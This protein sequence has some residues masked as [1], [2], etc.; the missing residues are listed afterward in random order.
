MGE[1]VIIRSKLSPDLSLAELTVP[2]ELTEYNFDEE[3]VDRE[4]MELRMKNA[5][6]VEAAS[7][8]GGD[9]IELMVEERGKCF[10]AT[11]G[12]GLLGKATEQS[13]L[14]MKLGE[15][16]IPT[17]GPFNGKCVT[18]RDIKRRMI[19]DF[20]D[21]MAAGLGYASAS[22]YRESRMET[23]RSQARRDKARELT[24]TE[25]LSRIEQTELLPFGTELE[26]LIRDYRGI[27]EE[28]FRSRSMDEAS[29]KAE[30]LEQMFGVR[31][32]EELDKMT[33][34]SAET[35]L[36]MA[37]VGQKIAME[38]GFVFGEAE[39]EK[40]IQAH[41]EKYLMD[42]EAVRRNTSF[43]SALVEEYVKLLISEQIAR[44]ESSMKEV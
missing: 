33:A 22:V 36:K 4:I 14:G 34:A 40:Q 38:Q 12:L 32:M 9:F 26:E 44:T 15:S 5:A 43:L 3:A 8:Q 31:S 11:I 20:S 17:D 21:Q 29:L 42:V 10:P 25:C 41:A 28:L 27:N 13:F 37:I 30:E 35:N 1:Q 6:I 19:P 24:Q 7:I 2:E 18:I 39:Y 23:L 16:L